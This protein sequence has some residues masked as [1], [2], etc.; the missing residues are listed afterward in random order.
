MTPPRQQS[1]RAACCVAATKTSS[2]FGA[3][4]LHA[5]VDAG[6][7]QLA[8]Y[9]VRAAAR[10]VARARADCAPICAIAD[11]S[12][13]A[14]QRGLYARADYRTRPAATCAGQCVAEFA[15]TAVGD[16]LAAIEYRQPVAAF[17]FVHVVRGNQN[18]RARI[19]E[20]EQRIPEFAPRLRI[21][22]AASA[23]RAAAIRVRSAPPRRARGA[24]S[25]RPTS[26][27]QAGRAVRRASS[28][29][30]IRRC[31]CLRARG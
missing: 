9:D 18:R 10:Q 26:C 12:G 4:R 20:C 14:L 24:A 8:L 30:A 5:R 3:G 22:R 6:L 7:P 13:Q 1:R 31:A 23:R 25:V 29:R 15:R 17:G 2:R 11:D 27:R 16:Q 21:D 28:V 19:D